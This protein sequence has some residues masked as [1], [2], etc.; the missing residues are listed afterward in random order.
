MNIEEIN[1]R[2]KSG[3]SVPVERAYLKAAEWTAIYDVLKAIANPN[4]ENIESELGSLHRA[5]MLKHAQE[6]AQFI[7]FALGMPLPL[8]DPT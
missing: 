1:D 4:F 2:F 7:R 3:N 5:G 8:E 6:N